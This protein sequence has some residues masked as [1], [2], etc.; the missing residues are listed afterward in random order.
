MHQVVV[1]QGQPSNWIYT[2]TSNM[3][4]W[5]MPMAFKSQGHLCLANLYSVSHN[6][7]ECS[8]DDKIAR[9]VLGI[10]LYLFV[11]H[12]GMNDRGS[13]CNF[14]NA[15]SAFR[16]LHVDPLS[17]IPPW[18][19]NKLN[20]IL[21]FILY[22]NCPVLAMKYPFLNTQQGGIQNSRRSSRLIRHACRFMEKW[23]SKFYLYVYRSR[24]HWKCKYFAFM[25]VDPKMLEALAN[26][27][28]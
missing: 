16:N 25:T 8:T 7:N 24:K 4:I 3:T 20:S 1:L 27:M 28:K 23:M 22:Q 11:S 19:T 6:A 5:I 15:Q 26:S 2:H 10:E 14:R 9:A 21:I 18:E 17:F 12:G 13:T